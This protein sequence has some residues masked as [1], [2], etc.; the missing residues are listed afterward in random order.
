MQNRELGHHLRCHTLTLFNR[1]FLYVFICAFLVE[2]VYLLWTI[3]GL[4]FCIPDCILTLTT[5]LMDLLDPVS[6]FADAAA[7]P[8]E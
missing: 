6:R 2:R 1:G 4:E 8:V 7:A 3:L 5:S